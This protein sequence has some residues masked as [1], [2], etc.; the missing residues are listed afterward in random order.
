[1]RVGLHLS[2]YPSGK[3]HGG[4]ATY[5]YT[6]ANAF[7]ECG[8]EVH[9][10]QKI[11]LQEDRLDKRISIYRIAPQP[12]TPWVSRFSRLLDKPEIRHQ[13]TFSKAALNVFNAVSEK[14]PLDIVQLPEY[15]GEAIEFRKTPYPVV[16]R[17]HT[18]TFLLDRLNGITPDSRRRAWYRF[19]YRA[20]RR[21]DALI[22]SSEGLK[23]EVCSFYDIP[24]KKVRVIR[25]PVKIVK[26]APLSVIN[27]EGQGLT[28]LYAGRL[29]KRKG[30]E[31]LIHALPMLLQ[32]NPD[33]RFVIAGQDA[34]D[35][36]RYQKTLQALS[37]SHPNRI[38]L[39][40]G[41]SRTALQEWYAMAD[42]V[43]VPSLF[44]NSPNVLFEAM[45]AGIACAASDTGGID[46][47]V[48]SGEN[49]LLFPP[50]DSK[51]LHQSVTELIRDSA[52]RQRLGQA[53]ATRIR[54]DHA[55]EAIAREML[56]FYGTL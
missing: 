27:K 35:G 13:R 36:E 50:G 7:A 49:G 32:D 40:G 39:T 11:G 19:E 41:L 29:E 38:V 56:S 28:V 34:T 24:L 31:T 12:L 53:A 54:R 52:L 44:D 18:P 55:P 30:I 4:M 23:K 45:A 6:L 26:S 5:V 2:E 15:N 21:A 37:V 33:A 8:Q 17:F 51:S 9:L 43:L 10:V 20:I 47:M 16:I 46:E 22:S 42:V 14:Q 25:N 48:T 3:A 1:M